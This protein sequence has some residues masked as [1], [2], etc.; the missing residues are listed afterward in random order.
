MKATVGMLTDITRWQW[1]QLRV[2]GA[3]TCSRKVNGRQHV[4]KTHVNNLNQQDVE[5]QSQKVVLH[6]QQKDLRS[7]VAQPIE[8][9]YEV[10]KQHRS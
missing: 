10:A 6:N 3:P 5:V 2:A 1:L 9:V 7:L 8:Q 4:R